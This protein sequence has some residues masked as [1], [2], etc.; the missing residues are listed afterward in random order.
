MLKSYV[1]QTKL[2]N[3]EACVICKSKNNLEMHHVKALRKDGKDLQDKYMIGLMQAM[4]R[5]QI[6]VCRNCHNDIHNGKYD[7]NS[8]KFY[9]S[10]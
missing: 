8:L 7:G 6:C 3:S 9:S 5:K 10:T 1:R 4:N 2:K